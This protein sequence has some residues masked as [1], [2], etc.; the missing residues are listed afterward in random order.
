MDNTN[1]HVKILYTNWRGEQAWRTIAPIRLWFG[2]TEWHKDK[3]WLLT[4]I[5]VEKGTERDF[6]MKDIQKW[7][8]DAQSPSD[9]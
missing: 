8:D 6:A 5:D 7:Q 4:A 3:Q 1:N 9:T 2:A